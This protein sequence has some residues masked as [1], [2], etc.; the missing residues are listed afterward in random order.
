[1]VNRTIK[2]HRDYLSKRLKHN[3]LSIERVTGLPKCINDIS[4]DL[5]VDAGEYYYKLKL[6][7]V[8]EPV[9]CEITTLFVYALVVQSKIYVNENGSYVR[10]SSFKN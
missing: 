9:Y 10:R 5:F 7:D 1:M 6:Q 2:F 3:I 4:F 8:P